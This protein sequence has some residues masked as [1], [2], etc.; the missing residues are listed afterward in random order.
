MV[1]RQARPCSICLL[2]EPPVVPS[3]VG[4]LVMRRGSP[5]GSNYL[6]SVMAQCTSTWQLQ[7]HCGGIVS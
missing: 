6:H 1:L 3:S 7:S 4:R 2:A 5:S